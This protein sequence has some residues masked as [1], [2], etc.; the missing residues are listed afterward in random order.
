MNSTAPSQNKSSVFAT[1]PCRGLSLSR[2][3]HVTRI[4]DCDFFWLS[5]H[6]PLSQCFSACEIIGNFYHLVSP[7]LCLFFPRAYEGV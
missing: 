7:S 5:S 3:V 6:L 2:W 4:A 1:P